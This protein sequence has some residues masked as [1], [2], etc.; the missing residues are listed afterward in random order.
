MPG[1][2]PVRFFSVSRGRV[3]F[4][5]TP[6][7][8]AHHPPVCHPLVQRNP[9]TG[10]ESQLIGAHAAQIADW[11]VARGAD[12]LEALLREAAADGPHYSHAWRAGDIVIW[13]NR[14][15][16]HRATPYDWVRHERLMQRTTISNQAILTTPA[17]LS[18]AS[19][20]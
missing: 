16:L 7:E 6:E 4:E 1:R 14:S 20:S 10:R 5:F 3:G 13:D 8:A 18:L 9:H 2:R 19:S 12:L 17:Y 15:V 11:P